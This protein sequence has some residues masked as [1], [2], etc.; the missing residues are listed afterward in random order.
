MSKREPIASQESE[1]RSYRK[2]TMAELGS[3][4]ALTQ[5]DGDSD[6]WDWGAGFIKRGCG[7]PPPF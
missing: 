6:K 3:I 7:C 2:P 5:G 4:V 1:A